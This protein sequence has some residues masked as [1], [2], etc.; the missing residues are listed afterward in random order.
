MAAGGLPTTRN[1]LFVKQIMPPLVS[2][3]PSMP[4]VLDKRVVKD[5]SAACSG[6]V[7]VDQPSRAQPVVEVVAPEPEDMVSIGM[8][9]E[10]LSV[11]D[12]VVQAQ[13]DDL[14][15]HQPQHGDPAELVAGD[16][17]G[18]VRRPN[19][20]YSADEYDLSHVFVTTGKGV[21]R[22]YVKV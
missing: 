7:R 17:L 12:A 20:R 21:V 13:T 5:D 4:V 8:N 1:I 22:R 16:R 6:P 3:V 11:G 10:E 15:G 14:R 19:V 18:R 9:D 2:D